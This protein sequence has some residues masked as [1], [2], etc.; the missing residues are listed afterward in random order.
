MNA[1]ALAFS[2]ANSNSTIKLAL[3]CSE[4]QAKIERPKKP[5]VGFVG[6]KPTDLDQ[7]PYGE[8]V[9]TQIDG[10]QWVCTQEGTKRFEADL[11]AF[12]AWKSYRASMRAWRKKFPLSAR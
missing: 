5:S 2:K 1:F 6:V 4:A 11:R 12:E 8:F 9:D 3:A 10:W 7:Y